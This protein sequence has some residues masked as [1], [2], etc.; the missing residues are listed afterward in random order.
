[1]EA[2]LDDLTN[3]EI[4]TPKRKQKKSNT[5]SISASN[6]QDSI[7]EENEYLKNCLKERDEL[8][9][10]LTNK[11]EDHL[12]TIKQIEI[13][14]DSLRDVCGRCSFKLI[15]LLIVFSK[16][17]ENEKSKLLEFAKSVYKAFGTPTD[18]EEITVNDANKQSTVCL[19][20]NFPNVRVSSHTKV[21][22]D[23]EL[24]TDKTAS[25]LFR[26]VITS[27]IKDQDV[28]CQSNYLKLMDKH[29]DIVLACYSES[30]YL[31]F[32]KS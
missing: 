19:T 2:K 27:I 26:I 15:L 18:I 32:R 5:I 21:Q 17:D 6:N 24:K 31:F 7:D 16:L 23:N 29:A 20:S 3:Y 4:E 10:T 9:K 13:R 30:V 25:T 14:N 28:W 1:M 12:K 8:I 11:N 22:L